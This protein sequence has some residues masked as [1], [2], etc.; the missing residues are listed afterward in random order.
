MI[1]SVYGFSAS[2]YR[3]GTQRVDIYH[4]IPMSGIKKISIIFAKIKQPEHSFRLKFTDHEKNIDDNS[5]AD[6]V[7]TG[8][9]FTG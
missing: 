5:W 2:K 7:A 8:R 3:Y 4:S 1:L 6:Y 9:S